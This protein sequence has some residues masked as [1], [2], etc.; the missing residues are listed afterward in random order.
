MT[1]LLFTLIASASEAAKLAEALTEH[2]VAEGEQW[3][4]TAMPYAGGF[5]IEI[6]DERG[7]FVGFL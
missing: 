5:R 4:Y 1:N 6:R 7:E 3:T 2:D